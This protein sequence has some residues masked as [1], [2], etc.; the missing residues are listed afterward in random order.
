MVPQVHGVELLVACESEEVVAGLHGGRAEISAGVS[1]HLEVAR[2]P[3]HRASRVERGASV[4]AHKE[5]H[6]P[7]TPQKACLQP[8][9]GTAV[10]KVLNSLTV[11]LTRSRSHTLSLTHAHSLTL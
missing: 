2:Y 4:W 3:W 1:G 7:R 8:Y 11:S 10:I 5:A 9:I 6:A